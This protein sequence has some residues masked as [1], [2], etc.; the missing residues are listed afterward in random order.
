MIRIVPLTAIEDSPAGQFGH[1]GY[2]TTYAITGTYT[3]DAVRFELDGVARRNDPGLI[4][5]QEHHRACFRRLDR[6][7]SN[8][9]TTTMAICIA[10]PNR[11]LI[12]RVILPPQSIK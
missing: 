8:N 11:V 9:P 1:N 6:K 4:T 2:T 12:S 3:P 7:Y 5:L 10:A